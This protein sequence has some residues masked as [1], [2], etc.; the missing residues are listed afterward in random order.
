MAFFENFGQEPHKKENLLNDSLVIIVRGLLL[1]ENTKHFRQVSGSTVLRVWKLSDGEY[2][3]LYI[4]ISFF[5]RCRLKL[6]V[7]LQLA[8]IAVCK[9]TE[10]KLLPGTE[11]EADTESG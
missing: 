3:I 8:E 7:I 6:P 9:L 1:H 11:T 10:C 5:I 2:S 4:P